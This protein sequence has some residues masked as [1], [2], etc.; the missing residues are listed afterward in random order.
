VSA[1]FIIERPRA[2]DLEEDFEF[3]PIPTGAFGN[4]EGPASKFQLGNPASHN[5]YLFNYDIMENIV[6]S[7]FYVKFADLPPRAL[8]F[9]HSIHLLEGDQLHVRLTVR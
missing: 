1:S 4:W 8:A 9:H 2:K 5:V 3:N 6:V 7:H